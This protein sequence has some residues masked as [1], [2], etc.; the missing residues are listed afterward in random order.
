MEIEQITTNHVV[1][2]V[3]VCDL[4]LHNYIRRAGRRVNN[5]KPSAEGSF[6]RAK[7][8]GGGLYSVLMGSCCHLLAPGA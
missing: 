2:L 3:L 6:C 5:P 4:R 7:A 8:A 1:R